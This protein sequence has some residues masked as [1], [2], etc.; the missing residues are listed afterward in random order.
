MIEHIS[1]KIKYKNICNCKKE[2]LFLYWCNKIKVKDRG[3]SI[4]RRKRKEKK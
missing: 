1:M 3:K 2:T 4:N